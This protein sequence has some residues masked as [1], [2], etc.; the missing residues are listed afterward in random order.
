MERFVSS[1]PTIAILL[2]FKLNIMKEIKRG[3]YGQIETKSSVCVEWS[4]E[5]IRSRGWICTNNQGMEVLQTMI[6]NHDANWGINWITLDNWCEEMGLKYDN[7]PKVINK[8]EF[9]KKIK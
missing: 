3:E 8:N 7:K 6:E 1:L 5:D 2:E 9:L 4:V